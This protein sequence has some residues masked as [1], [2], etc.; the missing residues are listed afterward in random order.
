MNY[1]LLTFQE[2]LFKSLIYHLA[3]QMKETSSQFSSFC[4]FIIRKCSLGLQIILTSF[5]F[6]ESSVFY[7]L[8]CKFLVLTLRFERILFYYNLSHRL[9][10]TIHK[11]K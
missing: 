7:F 8:I 3:S 2:P 6:E 9:P 11:T 1:E 5:D 4:L 10:A